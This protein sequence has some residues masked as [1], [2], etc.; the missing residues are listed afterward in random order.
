MAFT[1][2]KALGWEVGKSLVEEDLVGKARE[3]WKRPGQKAK[4]LPPR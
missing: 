2:I 3:S 1:F 4:V